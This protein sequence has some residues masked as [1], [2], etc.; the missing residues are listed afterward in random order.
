MRHR[1]RLVASVISSALLA[2]VGTAGASASGSSSC[3]ADVARAAG[4]VSTGDCARSQTFR[5]ASH[6]VRSR[7]VDP[8]CQLSGLETTKSK[9]HRPAV[10]VKVE[11]DPA[12][13]PLSGL[14]KADMVVEEPVEGGMTRFVAFFHCNDAEMVG[15]IRSARDT[16]PSIVEP[17]TSLVAA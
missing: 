14:D 7:F 11:N 3:H 2:T 5:T 9:M 4:V 16:D 12:A 15:P 17:I 13:Y 1:R 6:R 8:T 10:A